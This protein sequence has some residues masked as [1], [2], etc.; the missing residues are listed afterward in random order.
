[1]IKAYQKPIVFCDVET[2]GSRKYGARV[3]DVAFIRFENGKEV[4]R[5]ETLVNPEMSIPYNIQ[6]ITGIN[7]Q[8]VKD[9]PI[10]SEIADRIFEICDGAT[11]VAHNVKFDWSFIHGQLKV[12]GIDLKCEKLCTVLLSRRLFPY[13]R[14]H[15][16]SAIIDRYG[17]HCSAR[18]RAMGD[19]DVL[20]Q[21]AKYIDENIEEKALLEAISGAKPKV[22]LPPNVTQK[23]V[24]VLPKNPGVYS[25]YADNGELLYIGKSINIYKR[26][27]SHFTNA[28]YNKKSKKI[29]EQVHSIDTITTASDLGASLLELYK[30]KTES[31][32]YNRKSTRIQRLW[33]VTLEK[34]ETGYL[35]AQLKSSQNLSTEKLPEIRGIFRSAIKAKEFLA[36]A[37]KEQKLC[38]KLMG[39][40]KMSDGPCFSSQLHI[41][42]GACTGKPDVGE[43]NKAVEKVFETRRLRA[44]PHNGPKEIIKN[45]PQL[46]ISERF[47]IDNWILQKAEVI[48]FEE[49][50]DLFP[51]ADLSFDYEMYKVLVRHLTRKY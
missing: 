15:S 2:T 35:T 46:G 18:H 42:S 4:D 45:N 1:M 16:L 19:T 41:C 11:F 24:D 27:L 36:L 47:V 13:E 32:L 28:A 33:F 23:Q 5:F 31:P 12:Q 43:Y 29:W 34:N 37:A 10:F 7:D 6:Q 25:F 49:P 44:W 22:S 51:V 17:F 20:V 39:A 26:V 30:I 40:E 3:T 14:G 48:E 38:P 9:A 50:Y 21:F 8:M